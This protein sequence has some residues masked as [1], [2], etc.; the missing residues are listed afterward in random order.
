MFEGL[1]VAIVTPFDAD[2]RLDEAMLRRLVA[3]HVENGTDG[4]V[5]C[6][7]TGENPT[8]SPE[9]HERIIRIV[10][11]EAAGRLKV[12]AGAG[13]FST[14][15]TVRRAR[16]ARDLGADGL[17]II[18]PYYNKPQQ[19][20]LF[21]HFETV[22]K[23]AGAP[24]MMYNVPGRTGVNLL[25]ATVERLSR[26]PGIVA[27]KEASGDLN[28]VSDTIARCGDRLTVLAGDDS[29]TLPIMAVGGRGIV[30]VLGNALPD[31]M[32][33]MVHA[34]LEGRWDA[35]RA[36]HLALFEL[37]QA[38]FVETNPAPIKYFMKAVGFDVGDV[39]PPLAPLQEASRKRLEA[40][41]KTHGHAF[42][43]PVARS[44]G[45]A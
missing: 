39:R 7:T 10:V 12:V 45:L 40:L 14:P 19:A 15:E 33:A 29:L 44:R 13:T 41:A 21:T 5:P 3:F 9:E 26:V 8:F 42:P 31:R 6:G 2:G 17:L 16:R 1:Y 38:M 24:I 28:Q 30:S 23:E 37:C 20:G 4:L 18:T 27:L 35:A 36:A 11:E 43:E 32:R 22:A 34:A 25:P